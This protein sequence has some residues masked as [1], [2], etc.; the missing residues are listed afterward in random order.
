MEKFI[1]FRWLLLFSGL[2]K[3]SLWNWEKDDG[4]GCCVTGLNIVDYYYITRQEKSYPV[5][6]RMKVKVID[7]IDL[8]WILI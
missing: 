5:L 7:R 1:S 2:Q 6:V 3:D 4:L 8:R